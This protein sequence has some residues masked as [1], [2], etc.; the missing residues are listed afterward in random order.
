MKLSEL[1]YRAACLRD[2]ENRRIDKRRKAIDRFK[3]IFSMGKSKRGLVAIPN[4]I[5]K[6]FTEA[7]GNR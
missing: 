6:R 5:R 1:L 2:T 4:K 3:D 7:R